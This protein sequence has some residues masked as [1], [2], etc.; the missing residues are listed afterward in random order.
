MHLS[1]CLTLISAKADWNPSAWK[2]G[3]KLSK[4]PVVPPRGANASRSVA[5]TLNT[6]KSQTVVIRLSNEIA[7]NH[8]KT[9]STTDSTT[10]LLAQTQIDLMR[11]V[12]TTSKRPILAATILHH[13]APAARSAY[14]LPQDTLQLSQPHHSSHRSRYITRHYQ[15]SAPRLGC[16][17]SQVFRP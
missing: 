11:Q 9:M 1:V 4:Q 6:T 2:R 12:P 13:T 5:V 3:S 14:L 15:V 8:T 16:R 7:P 10:V 17:V